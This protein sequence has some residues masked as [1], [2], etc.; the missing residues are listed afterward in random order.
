MELIS[1]GLQMKLRPY[2]KADSEDWA[3]VTVD[4]NCN[5]F[6]GEFVAWLQLQDVRRFKAE[7][8][9]MYESVGIP[10]KARL[11]SAEPDID[12]E[13]NMDVRGHIVGSYRFESERRNGI[14]TVLSGEFE[15]DQSFLPDLTKQVDALACALSA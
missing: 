8:A 7:L 9:A 3:K 13:L 14:P 12:V 2:L 6:R 11:C 15:I 4:V 5:G 1:A 10:T